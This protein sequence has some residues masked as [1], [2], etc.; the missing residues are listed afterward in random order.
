MSEDEKVEWKSAKYV[1]DDYDKKMEQLFVM[2]DHCKE[3]RAIRKQALLMKVGFIIAL[4][5]LLLVIIFCSGCSNP[6]RQQ[7]QNFTLSI[8][9]DRSDTN[10]IFAEY[11]F[12]RN[13]SI[14]GFMLPVLL[15]DT[16]IYEHKGSIIADIGWSYYQ[17]VSK[18]N[19]N[20]LISVRGFKDTTV[21]LK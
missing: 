6:V 4:M 10:K 17:K 2:R 9:C 14:S 8:V 1:W 20:P 16:L 19:F 13:D 5:V 11:C 7:E 21:I 15:A 3:V 12:I 18:K